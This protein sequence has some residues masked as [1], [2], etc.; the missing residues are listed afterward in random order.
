MRVFRGLLTKHRIFDLVSHMEELQQRVQQLEKLISE[1][2]AIA[3]PSV[4]AKAVGLVRLVMDFHG[5]ALERMVE[6]VAASGKLGQEIFDAFTR[7]DLIRHVLLLHGLHPEDVETRVRRALEKVR[8]YLQ[9]HGGDAQLRGIDNGVVRLSLVGS[10]KGCPS[11]TQTLKL[12]IERAIYEAAPDVTEI[13]AEGSIDQ[14]PASASPQAR[15][16][17]TGVE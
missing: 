6:I 9:T 12:A 8:P 5:A 14:T 2:E 13:L 1:I 11:S 4:R 7:D 10:C 15:T 17:P 16:C 3:D